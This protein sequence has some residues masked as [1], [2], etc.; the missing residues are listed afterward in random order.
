MSAIISTKTMCFCNLKKI[1]LLHPQKDLLT[2]SLVFSHGDYHSLTFHY[3]LLL[4]LQHDLCQQMTVA[5]S[6]VSFHAA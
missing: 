1:N 5:H 6:V 4:V 2:V 3:A